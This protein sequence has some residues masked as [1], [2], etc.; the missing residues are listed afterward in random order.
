MRHTTLLSLLVVV[1]CMVLV[2]LS[3]PAHAA[4][5]SVATPETVFLQYGPVGAACVVEAGCIVLLF[6]QSRAERLEA[7]K[8]ADDVAREHKIEIKNERD[9]WDRERERWDAA[10]REMTSRVVDAQARQ[11][12]VLGDVV[13]VMRSVMDI[14]PTVVRTVERVEEHQRPRAR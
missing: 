13:T 6:W 8:R 11:T 3:V 4:D 1:G 12:T 14:L 2:G 9:K 5:P 7:Q 10:Q